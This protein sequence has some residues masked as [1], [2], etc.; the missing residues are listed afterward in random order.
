MET[1]KSVNALPTGSSRDLYIAHGAYIKAIENHSKQILDVISSVVKLQSV[2]GNITMRDGEEK[3]ELIQE[4]NDIMLERINSNLDEISGIK[5]SGDTLLVTEVKHIQLPKKYI[6]SSVRNDKIDSFDLQSAKLITAKNIVRP[7]FNFKTPPDN[8]N[9]AFVPRI[10]EKPNLLKPLAVLPEYDEDSNIISYLHPYEFE[11]EKFE[12]PQNL[13]VKVEPKDPRKLEDT[14]LVY[15]D[16]ETKL[17]EMVEELLKVT[18]IAVDLEHHWY[19]T[20]QVS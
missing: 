18:E 1:T 13:L 12:P 10:K 5:K 2:K 15:V 3:F 4:S 11:I 17:K 14:P 20:F 7:Q 9:T 19:R 8:S 16:D 6:L